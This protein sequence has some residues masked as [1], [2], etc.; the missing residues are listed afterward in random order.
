MVHDNGRQSLASFIKRQLNDLYNRGFIELF[1][2]L[3]KSF[4]LLLFLPVAIVVRFISPFTLIRVGAL[5]SERIG[6]YA[7]NTELYLCE[8][9][10]GLQP[11]QAID[12]FFNEPIICNYQLKKMWGRTLY[13]TELALCL[14]RAIRF[15]P[16]HKKHVINIPSDRDI[17]SIL[18]HQQSHLSFTFDEEEQGRIALQKLGIQDKTPFI[19]FHARDK[20]FLDT[21]FPKGEW[22]YHDYRDSNIQYLIPAMEELVRRGYAAI[23]MGAV[24]QEPLITTNTK[25]I[26]Y[27]TKA[28]TDFL[29]IY[30]SAKCLFF[31]GCTAGIA[32]VAKIFRRPIVLANLL[33]INLIPTGSK[34]CVFIYK[35]L[36]L[37]KEHRF[38]TFR[39]IRK[40]G[41]GGFLRTEQYDQIGVDVVE[42]TS[43]EIMAVAVE[44]EERLKGKWL[45]TEDDEELQRHFRSLFTPDELRGTDYSRI[46]RDFLRQ[47]K[48]LL[49]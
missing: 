16:G 49:K 36:F 37:R 32:S 38:M 18:I 4:L 14:Y 25:I 23:R 30:L 3:N 11:R 47:N 44:M 12:F 21:M 45:I 35:K 22:N 19:C 8:R 5:R 13:V 29:D 2:K 10:A 33:P 26:D 27:A 1:Q 48:N 43:D 7:A 40:S 41:A 15:L 17:H 6:H 39:E 31:L 28:K 34:E 24:V 20:I 46:G 42:N 9:D